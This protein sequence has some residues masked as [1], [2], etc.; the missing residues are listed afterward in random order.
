MTIEQAKKIDLVEYLTTRGHRPVRI[1]GNNWWFLSPIRNEKHASFK[2]NTERNEWYDFGAGCGGDI[3]ELAK[4]LYHLSYIP[5]I[6]RRL[7]EGAVK[8]PAQVS[9]QT[10]KPNTTILIDKAKRNIQLKPLY[11]YVLKNYLRSRHISLNVGNTYCKEIHYEVNGHSYFG[12]AFLNQSGGMEI[13]NSFFKGCE[14]HKD[15]SIIRWTSDITQASCCVFEGFFDFLSYMTL[16]EKGDTKV[17]LSDDADYI[18]LNS[19]S[20]IGKI[21][22]VIEQYDC[23]HCYLDNDVAGQKAT[24]TIVSLYPEKVIDESHRY[25]SHNDLNDMLIHGGI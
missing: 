14:G 13:R 10:K 25:Q 17:C 3:I 12:I 9:T 22:S 16:K 21:F 1:K 6:L 11:H 23:I 4:H 18:V 7:E 2:V 19:V 15:I 20:N 5:D 24:E 8:I